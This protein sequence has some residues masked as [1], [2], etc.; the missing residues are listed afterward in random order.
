MLQ[1]AHR[2]CLSTTGFDCCHCGSDVTSASQACRLASILQS[3][4]LC[5]AESACRPTLARPDIICMQQAS[6]CMPNSSM[7]YTQQDSEYGVTQLKAPILLQ[8]Q[9][10]TQPTTQEIATA[11]CLPLMRHNAAQSQGGMAC[12]ALKSLSADS[13][14]T[15][16]H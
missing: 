7:R 16:H 15:C 12:G 6:A 10:A 2:H 3:M 14:K 1:E 9:A 13:S 4:H 11:T 8:A 5:N